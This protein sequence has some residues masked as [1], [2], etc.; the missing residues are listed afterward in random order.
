MNDEWGDIILSQNSSNN[1]KK[2]KNPNL[3]AGTAFDIQS[4]LY[5]RSAATR[6]ND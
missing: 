3:K 5:A 6:T 4:S 2:Q 1:H